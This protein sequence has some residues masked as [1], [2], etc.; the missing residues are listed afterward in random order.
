MQG[1]N[2]KKQYKV[3]IFSIRTGEKRETGSE[4]N[5]VSTNLKPTSATILFNHDFFFSFFFFFFFLR[6]KSLCHFH[7]ASPT[8]E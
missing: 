4:I 3:T 8:G 2:K 1:G 6:I 7:S 5:P